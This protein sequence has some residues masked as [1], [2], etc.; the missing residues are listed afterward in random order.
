MTGSA[1]ESTTY[2]RLAELYDP[3]YRFKDYQKE[4][5]TLHHLVR[6]Y[7][8]PRARSLLDVACG[9]GEHLRFLR[10]W[11]NVA[12]VDASRSMLRVARAKLPGVP[13]TLGRMESFRTTRRYEVVTCLFSAI[14]YLRD[15]RSVRRAFEHFHDALVPGGIV[16]LEPFIAPDRWRPGSAH[17]L[18]VEAGGVRVVRMTVSERRRGEAV[19]PMHYLVGDR[20]GVRHYLEVH[21]CHLL[22]IPRLRRWLEQAGFEVRWAPK[23]MPSGRGLLIGVRRGGGPLAVG[24]GRPPRRAVRPP[25]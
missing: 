14:G 5:R 12:G 21:V 8:P 16:L 19:M 18:D 1:G 2:G 13:L 6:R 11:Y 24:A 22:P 20:T 7:G 25:P 10:R 9:T 23:A 4:A 15:P 3:I 17:V